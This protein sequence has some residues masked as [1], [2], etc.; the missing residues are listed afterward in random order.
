MQ[1]DTLLLRLLSIEQ[2]GTP[3]EPDDPEGGDPWPAT[4]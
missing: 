2:L 1:E 3:D 4:M